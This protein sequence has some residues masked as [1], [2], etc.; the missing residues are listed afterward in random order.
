VKA[1]E[2]IYA[3][4]KGRIGE[5]NAALEEKPE[6]VNED[7]FGDGWLLRIENADDAQAELMSAADY[8]EMIGEGD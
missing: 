4:V 7:P 8:A 6:L 1:V 2:D 3:P 5:V